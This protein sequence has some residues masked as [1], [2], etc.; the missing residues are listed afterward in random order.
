MTIGQSVMRNRPPSAAAVA[1]RA[2]AVIAFLFGPG[3]G[4]PA[5]ADKAPPPGEAAA[6]PAG[7]ARS[8]GPVTNLPL[9]RFVSMKASR[10]NVR[11]GPSLKHRID[12]V[13]TR[14]G[15]PLEVTAEFGNWRRVRDQ[16][17]AGGW[18]HY[19]L[20]S[21]VRTVL[22][23]RDLAALHQTPSEDAPVTA[24]LE[25]GVIANLGACR[26]RWCRVTVDGSRGWILKAHVWG[27][28]PD[29]IRD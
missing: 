19:A 7:A 4:A 5:A 18:M 6:A 27:V 24:Y 21:G 20:L 1:A 15:M 12:W 8:R 16:E 14:R 9:P 2:L 26:P 28:Y 25:A 23:T 10:G 29:E 17:G 22:V 13:F 11:R 3:G